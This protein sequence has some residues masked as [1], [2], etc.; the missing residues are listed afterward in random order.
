MKYHVIQWVLWWCGLIPGAEISCRKAVE[1]NF[2]DHDS[3]T[4][5][6]NLSIPTKTNKERTKEI[7]LVLMKN[8]PFSYNISVCRNYYPHYTWLF[9]YHQWPHNI[10]P[11][12]FQHIKTGVLHPVHTRWQSFPVS[13]FSAQ[14]SRDPITPETIAF[15]LLCIF[16]LKLLSLELFHYSGPNCNT[17]RELHKTTVVNLPTSDTLWT[18][19]ISARSKFP[20]IIATW[21]WAE[22]KVERRGRRKH[23]RDR[24]TF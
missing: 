6:S 16:R 8:K 24:D 1:N 17:E 14:L 18:L 4:H 9:C 12:L 10:W 7:L 15:H 13:Y 19:M 21:E 5:L 3:D 2:P 20:A 23:V 22:R 11:T